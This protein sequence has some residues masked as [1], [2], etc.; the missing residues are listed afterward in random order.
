M[1]QSCMGLYCVNVLTGQVF[2]FDAEYHQIM[3]RTQCIFFCFRPFLFW[4]GIHCRWWFKEY[5][6]KI[7]LYI[8]LSSILESNMLRYEYESWSNTLRK[9]SY[10]RF[11]RQLCFFVS[12]VVL[13]FDTIW[14]HPSRRQITL[15]TSIRKFLLFFPYYVA[16]L[17][18][19]EFRCIDIVWNNLSEISF[20]WSEWNDF[21]PF[22]C[23]D[24][25]LVSSFDVSLR[26]YSHHS[27]SVQRFGLIR[28][29]CYRF[30]DSA[31]FYSLYTFLYSKS[32]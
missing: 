12:R 21:E 2:I 8:C 26:P 14:D 7:Y 17:R 20:W 24:N 4:A 30:L 27:I 9:S 3:F 19:R 29:F 15:K 1:S 10:S 31:K 16:W 13:S 28:I 18:W 32:I 5:G 25:D 6:K 23:L 11:F 22:W